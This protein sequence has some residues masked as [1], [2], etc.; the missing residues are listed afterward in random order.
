MSGNEFAALLVAVSGVVG[1][2]FAGVRNLRGDK[3]K[4]DVEASA[5][6]L[7]GYTGMVTALQTEI[8]RLKSDHAEDRTSWTAERAAMRHEHQTEMTRLRDEHRSQLKEVYERLDE[9]GSQ[10]YVLQHRPRDTRERG[11]DE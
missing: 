8:D 6:L 2:I 10:I 5:S 1:A 4:K 7:A 3:F 11:S 9:L